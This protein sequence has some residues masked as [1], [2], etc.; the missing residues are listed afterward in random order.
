[1]ALSMGTNIL[2]EDNIVNSTLSEESLSL[3]LPYYECTTR[4]RIATELK[5]FQKIIAMANAILVACIYSGMISFC[6]GMTRDVARWH[7]SLIL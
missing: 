1:M 3:H 6:T 2:N 5:L 4:S 7:Y